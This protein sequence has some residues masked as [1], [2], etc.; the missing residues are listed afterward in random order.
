M[1]LKFWGET[2]NGQWT[3]SVVDLKDGDADLNGSC[4]DFEW[5]YLDRITCFV[6]ES[7]ERNRIVLPLDFALAAPYCN[8]ILIA[9]SSV[10][11][12]ILQCNTVKMER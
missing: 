12:L 5:V 1:T 8:E 10:S 3:I 11:S 9:M 2:P 7:G 4:G 6:L